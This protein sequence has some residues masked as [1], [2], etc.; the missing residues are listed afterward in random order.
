[1]DPA[2]HN[3]IVNFIWGIADDV[4]RD[5]LGM[6]PAV[7]A[8]GDGDDVLVGRV[9]DG[10][11]GQ[12]ARFQVGG[13]ERDTL[14]TPSRSWPPRPRP[15]SLAIAHHARVSSPVGVRRRVSL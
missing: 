8:P 1:M 9:E 2:T 13:P 12:V 3:A 5:P 6:V 7:V 4:L 11:E 15:S 10:P 14:S